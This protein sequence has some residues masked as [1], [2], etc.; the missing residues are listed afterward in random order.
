MSKDY[1]HILG[2]GKEASPEEIKKA[3]RTLAHKHHPDRTGGDAEKF[4]EINEAYQV[5]HDPKKRATYD[6]FGSAAFD[7]RGPQSP[8]GFG[9]FT[10]DF[11]DFGFEDLGDLFGGMF[12]GGG[13]ARRRRGSHIQIDVELTFREA[14]FGAE[15]ELSLTKPSA[16]DRCGGVGAEPGTGMKTCSDCGGQGVRVVHQRTVIGTIQSKTTCSTCHGRGEVPKEICKTCQGSGVERRH[17]NLAVDIPAGVDDGSVLRLRGQGEAVTGGE[18]GD[19]LVRIHVA[20]DAR[21]ERDGDLIRSELK[22]GFT[23]AALGDRISTETVDGSVELE[24]PAGIQSGTELRL[25]GKGIPHRGGRGDH[26][27]TITVMTPKKL[28]RDQRRMLEEGDF[29]L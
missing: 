2:V 7:G 26:L 8:G 18:S 17:V 1:Y 13:R 29:R 4:K 21:F 6:Q 24:I 9:G 15:K 14:I 23:Q 28:S 12:G 16:C 20:S 19:L 25:R 5:L 3:F 10:G 22:I 11:S 27:V